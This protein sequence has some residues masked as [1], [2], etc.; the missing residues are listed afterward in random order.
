MGVA[1]NL[2][3]VESRITAACER[4][5]RPRAEVRL[6][7]VSKT[8]PASLILEAHAAGCR[9]FG[10]NKVQ[11]AAAKAEELASVPG[12]EWAL[13]GHLQ[14]NKAKLVVTFA[15]EFQALDSV[16]LAAELDKRLQQAGRGLD[17]LIEVNTSGEA[18]KFGVDPAEVVEFARAL[19]PFD[20]LNVRGLMTIAANTDDRRRISACFE[21]LARLRRA[22][23]DDDRLQGSF[24]EL[25]MGMSGDYEL[26][27]EHGATCI[28]VGTAIFGAR[29]YPV[30][31]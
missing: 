2:A 3:L 8:H 9:R 26:A 31:I 18:S 14:T 24:D 30:P 25:S 6:L 11:E 29:E 28:R 12:I 13:I 20:A 22:L 5:G 16:R 10:E 17:V 7:P 4:S 27:I 21:E 1:E 19:R 15:S 23:R